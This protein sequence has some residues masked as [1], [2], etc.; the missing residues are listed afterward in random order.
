M[1]ANQLT[2]TMVRMV[3]SEDNSPTTLESDT[4]EPGGKLDSSFDVNIPHRR[5]DSGLGYV[6]VTPQGTS[7]NHIGGDRGAEH[8][9]TGQYTVA[10]QV[11]DG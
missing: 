1:P 5:G 8:S 6:T 10:K 2:A 9:L 7:L 4:S 11:S 3:P